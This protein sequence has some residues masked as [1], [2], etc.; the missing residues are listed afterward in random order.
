MIFAALSNALLFSS[1]N[2]CV[3]SRLRLIPNHDRVIPSSRYRSLRWAVETRVLHKEQC[4]KFIIR[5]SEA[6]QRDDKNDKRALT[7]LKKTTNT[8]RRYCYVTPSWQ[9]Q[10]PE[11]SYRKST[12]KRS[13]ENYS[14]WGA[15]DPMHSCTIQST[16]LQLSLG[17][18]MF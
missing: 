13:V 14:D 8:T 17:Y 12:F 6:Y 5:L 11:S 9:A 10:L 16:S 2:L 15:G 3:Q 7:R 18:S 1:C 4:C